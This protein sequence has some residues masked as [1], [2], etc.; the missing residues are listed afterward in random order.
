[1][2][3]TSSSGSHEFREPVPTYRWE[4]I[5]GA[6][7]SGNSKTGSSARPS[8]DGKGH[9]L[10]HISLFVECAH[11]DHEMPERVARR[12]GVLAWKDM[13]LRIGSAL[14]RHIQRQ[15]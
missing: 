11:R 8:S 12:P 13:N 4:P 1:M 5:R 9:R 14:R 7:D 3:G 15:I 6:P 2:N 10:G